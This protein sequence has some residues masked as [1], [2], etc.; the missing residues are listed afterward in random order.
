MGDPDIY[1][2]VHRPQGEIDS[3]KTRYS[4]FDVSTI[5]PILRSFFGS[6][7]EIKQISPSGK[8]GTAHVIYFVEMGDGA[9]YVFR[10]NCGV[11]P[12]EIAM[13]AEKMI[14]ERLQQAAIP[15]NHVLFADISRKMYPFDYQ[16]VEMMDGGDIEL[17]FTGTKED[18]DRLSYELG[19]LIAKLGTVK[20]DGYGRWTLD[21]V[22]NGKLI[23]SKPRMSDY[24]SMC[25]HEDALHLA[26]AGIISSDLVDRLEGLFQTYAIY[27]NE[28]TPSIV[29]HDLA[30]HNL[31]TDGKNIT[32]IFDW[33]AS[34]SGD[35]ILDLASCPTW[36]TMYPREELL[37]AGYK[38]VTPLP[39]YFE[40]KY[41]IY[42]LRTL[43][44]KTAYALKR[45][46]MNDERRARLFE[47]LRPFGLL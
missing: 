33:E 37:L 38:S 32:A 3:Y 25:V 17:T 28:G 46:V 29:H 9:Q 1:Y 35:P 23:G 19:T 45:G 44:W 39:R 42:L 20:T 11:G 24:L 10:A 8:F 22:N 7:V 6:S 34:I 47:S 27:I 2:P 14:A 31:M 18:Y 5:T 43:L 36:K 26:E 21:G 13:K 15:V 41:R 30:D 16:I 12:P 40:E 4:D